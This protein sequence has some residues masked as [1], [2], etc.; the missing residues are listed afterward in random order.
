MNL[1]HNDMKSILLFTALV[2]FLGLSSFKV[3]KKN[4]TKAA[5]V[6]NNVITGTVMDKSTGEALT[7]VEVRIDGTDLKAYTDFDGKFSFEGVKSGNY[8]I[9]TNFISYKVAEIPALSVKSNEFH[10]LNIELAPVTK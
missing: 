7:G 4:A 1:K 5:P 8:K 10:A 2:L 6:I 9:C 3:E